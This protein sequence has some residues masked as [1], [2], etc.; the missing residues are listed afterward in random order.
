MY[1]STIIHI[2]SFSH[3]LVF[4]LCF[5]KYSPADGYPREPSHDLHFRIDGPAAYDILSKFE[6][7]WLKASKRHGIKKLERSNDDALLKIDRIPNLVGMLAAQSMNESDPEGWHVQDFRLI[8]SNSVKGF[9]KDPKNAKIKVFLGQS[10]GL[11]TDGNQLP[12]LVYVSRGKR[13][14]HNHHKKA[15]TMNALVRV[16]VMPENAPYLLNLDCYHY[17]NNSKALREGMCFMMDPLLGKKGEKVYYAQFPQRFDGIDRND[18]YANRNTVYFDTESIKFWMWDGFYDAFHS[19]NQH[20]CTSPPSSS[21]K[22]ETIEIE[23]PCQRDA[24]QQSSLHKLNVLV[25]PYFPNLKKWRRQCT[26]RD[27]LR[28]ISKNLER[29]EERVI[30]FQDKHDRL[31]DRNFLYYCHQELKQAL[32]GAYK[33]MNEALGCSY[34]MINADEDDA[35]LPI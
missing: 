14:G 3:K 10:G 5:P 9:P 19:V 21:A 16:S 13:P 25:Y 8:N 15:G 1:R 2:V 31:F 24:S 23:P 6:E 33:A 20:I 11:D 7:R 35:L 34:S 18:R 22:L 30:R 4:C 17:I 27:K 28:I 32:L 29:A 26:V 12:H